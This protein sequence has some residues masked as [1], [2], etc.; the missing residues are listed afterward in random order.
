MNK[1]CHD[2]FKQS[3]EAGSNG[4]LA[5]CDEHGQPLSEEHEWYG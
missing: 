5:G 3:Q 4:F 2:K 1:H